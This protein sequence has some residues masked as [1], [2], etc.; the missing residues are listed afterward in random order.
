[1]KEGINEEGVKE[2]IKREREE[3]KM[4]K[5]NNESSEGMKLWNRQV[6]IKN[7]CY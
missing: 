5:I 1:M 2:D 7:A 3:E 6:R 4:I